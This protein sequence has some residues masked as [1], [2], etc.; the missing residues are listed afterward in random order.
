MDAVRAVVQQPAGGHVVRDGREHAHVRYG[1]REGE[2]VQGGAQGDNKRVD[3][4]NRL[5]WWGVFHLLKFLEFLERDNVS[6]GGRESPKDRSGGTKYD[7]GGVVD[8][9]KS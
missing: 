6:G 3:I 4:R 1:E 7:G 8:A 9:G 5:L 2:P